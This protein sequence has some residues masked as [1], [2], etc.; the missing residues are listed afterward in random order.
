MSPEQRARAYCEY[1]GLD[2]DE[3]VIGWFRDEQKRIYRVHNPRWVFYLGART[4]YG[5][6]PP[7]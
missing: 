1:I 5:Q 3:M 4:D 6:R 2:P 7:P